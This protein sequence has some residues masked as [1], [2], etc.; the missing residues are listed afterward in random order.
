ML[1]VAIAVVAVAGC[2]G[3]SSRS[4]A[5]LSTSSTTASDSLA[6]TTSTTLLAPHATTSSSAVKKRL[7]G[8]GA[9]TSTLAT[10][11]TP[12]TTPQQGGATT[13]EP[14]REGVPTGP[15]GQQGF[16]P[17]A[18]LLFKMTGTGN[19]TTP[20]FKVPRSYAVVTYRSC[21][22][23]I[24]NT[25]IVTAHHA[26]GGASRLVVSQSGPAPVFG[27]KKLE[28][29]PGSIYLEIKTDCFW[30]IEVAQ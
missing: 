9:T 10:S 12:T 28:D 18:N 7:V 14:R 27:T 22:R 30:L 4:G 25:F 19:K 15:T 3:K 8:R 6:K 24:N 13:V 1:L 20:K 16:P 11:A 2:G 17:E 29:G 26:G 21:S 23:K 5:S